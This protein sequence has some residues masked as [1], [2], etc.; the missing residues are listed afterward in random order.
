M[1]G[2][3]LSV[4]MLVALIVGELALWRGQK[5]DHHPWK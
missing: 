3:V 2:T 1:I 4:A 5:D